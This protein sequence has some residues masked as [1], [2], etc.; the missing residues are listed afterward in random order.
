[1]LIQGFSLNLSQIHDLYRYTSQSGSVY[2]IALDWPANNVLSLGAP[3]TTS[4]TTV[5][6]LGYAENLKWKARGGSGI[7]IMIPPISPL[8]LP[9]QWVWTFKL[10][11]LKM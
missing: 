10:M 1:M 3:V 7:D 9:S 8:Q 11:N 6:M 4:Q 5:N 2:A